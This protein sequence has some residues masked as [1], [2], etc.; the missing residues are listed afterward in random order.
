MIRKKQFTLQYK[1]IIATNLHK[2]KLNFSYKIKE[3]RDFD[4]HPQDVVFIF[5]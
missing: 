3:N 1:M 5:F 2:I 4:L